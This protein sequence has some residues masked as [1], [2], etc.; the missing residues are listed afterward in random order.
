M[1]RSAWFRF[2]LVCS[3]S[4]LLNVSAL[5]ADDSVNSQ[6]IAKTL[7]SVPALELAPTAG[8]LVKQSDA[9]Q[10]DAT[11]REV[12]RRAIKINSSA[13]IS[14]VATIAG[15]K[16]EMASVAAGTA[17]ILMPK[18]AVSIAR[19][20]ASAAPSE[21]AK[22]VQAVCEAA[23]KQYKEISLAVASIVPSAGK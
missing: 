14:V 5:A 9:K 21:A 17:A 6:A 8:D 7:T 12:V 23:P 22:I 10:L 19:A 13:T 18:L 20:A 16:N 11:V 3:T 1:K 4:L 15:E 2:T